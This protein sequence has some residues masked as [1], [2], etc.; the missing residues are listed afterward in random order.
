[1]LHSTQIK[2]AQELQHLFVI[3]EGLKE[4]DLVLLEG[5]RKVKDKEQINYHFVTPDSVLSDLGLYAE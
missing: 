2:I 3:S 5:L 1:M 4:T